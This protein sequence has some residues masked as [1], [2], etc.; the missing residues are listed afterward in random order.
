MR[1]ERSVECAGSPEHTTAAEG[2]GIVLM[3]DGAIHRDRGAPCR[4]RHG[5]LDL[6]IGVGSEGLRVAG[7]GMCRRRSSARSRLGRPACLAASRVSVVH[8]FSFAC[9]PTGGCSTAERVTGRRSP[10]RKCS[11]SLIDHSPCLHRGIGAGPDEEVI[12]TT[13]WASSSVRR[14]ASVGFSPSRSAPGYT[15]LR[16]RRRGR[17]GLARL[18]Q[19]RQERQQQ[20]TFWYGQADGRGVDLGFRRREALCHATLS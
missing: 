13:R 20:E 11:V 6:A 18:G 12:E 14:V 19:Q 8:R 16:P 15:A 17:S 3:S 2:V 4:Q 10:S 1:A 5:L 9:W 7:A